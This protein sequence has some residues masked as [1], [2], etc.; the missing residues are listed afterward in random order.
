MFRMSIFKKIEKKRERP[1]TKEIIIR[2]LLN[3]FIWLIEVSCADERQQKK[4]CR[5]GTPKRRRKCRVILFV[6]QFA[7]CQFGKL[8][9]NAERIFQKEMGGVQ[10]QNW[11]AVRCARHSIHYIKRFD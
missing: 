3:L 1:R 9:V 11:P 8:F 2:P 10:R 6:V 5:N 7:I 4:N